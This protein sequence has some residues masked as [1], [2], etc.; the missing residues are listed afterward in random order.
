MAVHLVFVHELE[1]QLLLLGRAGPVA[2]GGFVGLGGHLHHV[3]GRGLLHA[4]NEAGVN[5]LLVH[6]LLEDIVN[7]PDL[8]GDVVEGR[9]F[10]LQRDTEVVAAV[11]GQPEFLA[12]GE[13]K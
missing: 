2:V 10:G 4:R 6:G 13:F 8:A 3:A 12:V 9:D 5:D 11:H 1:D 7:A